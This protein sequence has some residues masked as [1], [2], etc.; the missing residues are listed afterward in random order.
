MQ[1]DPITFS[2]GRAD[3]S[4]QARQMLDALGP[5]LRAVSAPMQIE[6]HTCDLPINTERFP[7][8][9]ELSAQRATAVMTYLIRNCGVDPE[10]ISTVGY[11]DTKPLA[12]NDT[13][14]G[15]QRNRRVDIVVL[16]RDLPYFGTDHAESQL[17]VPG[18]GEET[19]VEPVHLKPTI[20]LQERH[21]QSTGRRGPDTPTSFSP[22]ENR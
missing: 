5:S 4:D 12:P 17:R 22:G 19:P 2:I 14:A 18:P 16:A 3:L 8:N 1:A 9:W 21:R 10:Y 7:S 13:E 15:R 11:A 20:D 6:G